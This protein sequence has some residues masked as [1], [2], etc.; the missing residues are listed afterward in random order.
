MA[1]SLKLGAALKTR[2]QVNR[3][4]LFSTKPILQGEG[5]SVRKASVG[6]IDAARR[7]GI[8]QATSATVART[9][10]TVA[11]VKVS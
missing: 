3:N 9:T 8:Q 6:L 2:P 11:K 10:G 5:Y 7:A 1:Y 4:H